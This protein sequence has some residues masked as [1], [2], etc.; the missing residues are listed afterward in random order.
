MR[1]GASRKLLCVLSVFVVWFGLRCGPAARLLG[2]CPSKALT[3]TARAA[4]LE[5]AAGRVIR[6]GLAFEDIAVAAT[7]IGLVALAAFPGLGI[8][9]CSD[10]QGVLLVANVRTVGRDLS[11]D[12]MAYT[13]ESQKQDSVDSEA[14]HF[15]S[16]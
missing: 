4:R 16:P 6:A 1:R 7:P 3:L 2:G 12:D 13:E 5:L 9:A 8:T 15:R 10:A 14:F 11:Q